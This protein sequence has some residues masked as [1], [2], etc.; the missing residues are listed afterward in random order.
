VRALRLALAGGLALASAAIGVAAGFA[1]ASASG[2]VDGAG[3]WV[4]IGFAAGA[5]VLALLAARVFRL[6]EP[7]RERALVFATLGL[8]AASLLS[9]GVLEVGLANL[10]PALTFDRAARMS[11]AIFQQSDWL[12]FELRPDQREPVYAWESDRE[13]RYSTNSHGYRSAEFELAKPA[14]TVRVLVLGDSFAINIAVDDE[15]VHTAVLQRGFDALAPPSSS[16]GSGCRVEVINAGYAA[17]YSP[18]T[19]GAYL[20]QQ[21]FALDPDVVVVQ[22]FVLNDFKDLLENEVLET[23]EALPWRLRSRYRYVDDAGR[24]RSAHAW[25][26]RVPLLRHSHVFTHLYALLRIDR[27]PALLVPDFA[28][29]NF[30]NNSFGMR[31]R[32]AYA[33]SGE[34]PPVLQQ[35][36]ERST[37]YV[38]AMAAAAESR[39]VEFGL[40]VVPTGV[41]TSKQR[42]EAVY[43]E[44]PENWAL[45]NPQAQIAEA[46]EP[47]DVR[48]FDP[49]AAYRAAAATREL[50]LGK[51]G[52]GHWNKAG[53]ELTAELLQSWLSR[54][55]APVRA[56]TPR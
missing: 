3:M 32:H 35:A 54:E 26:Q 39:G 18:D 46:L 53:N 25:N 37:E 10:R 38:A 2:Q 16:T 15:D 47:H 20:L 30:A 5:S 21:G 49:L 31:P 6:R 29:A 34:R 45:P 27:L 52:N 22:Y 23:R 33:A 1:L 8:A 50:F 19:Y 48:V 13:V 56:C 11:P 55:L 4:A 24:F 41:Q 28:G 7:A 36:F 43:G 9:A 40:F 12:P 51:R 17:G 14:G 42:W 44:V